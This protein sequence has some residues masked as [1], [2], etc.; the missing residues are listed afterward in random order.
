MQHPFLINPQPRY[1]SPTHLNSIKASFHTT[2][3]QQGINTPVILITPPSWRE[4]EQ[5]IE[6][7]PHSKLLSKGGIADIL[8]MVVF[9][10]SV[11]CSKN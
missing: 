5:S 10:G 2:E 8:K 3:W 4:Y 9:L 6:T 11:P 7:S 1:F